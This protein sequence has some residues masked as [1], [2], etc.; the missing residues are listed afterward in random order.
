MQEFLAWLTSLPPLSLYLA[1]AL[2]AALENVFPPLPADTV[3]AFGS[4]LAARGEATVVGAFAA[5]WL[6][7]V[8]GAMAV[9]AAGRRWGSERASARL[10][11]FAGRNSEQRLDALYRRWGMMALFVSR[12]L[13]GVRAIVPP[14]AGALKLPVGP[15]VAA[16]SLASAIW[17]G[18]VTVAAYQVGANWDAL[19]ARIS[20]MTRTAGL[21]AGVIAAALV[22]A[23]LLSRRRRRARR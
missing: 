6:G 19:E 3:V 10:R 17:Y 16:I 1:L 15:V 11:R 21:V 13:P 4:F 5:T 8:A 2:T 12:F 7:N 18:F 9:Y 14:F 22:A 23:W 20:T